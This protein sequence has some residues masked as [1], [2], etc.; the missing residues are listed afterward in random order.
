[1]GGILMALVI[2]YF[3]ETVLIIFLF[4]KGYL[5]TK[6]VLQLLLMPVLNGKA[7]LYSFISAPEVRIG[8]A[9]GTGGS[10]SLPATE[11]PGVSSWL[12]QFLSM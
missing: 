3:L 7:I 1:M 9:F 10:Q 5:F 2:V 12:V 11:L 4:L 8:V 6:L